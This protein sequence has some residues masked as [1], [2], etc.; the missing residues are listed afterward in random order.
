MQGVLPGA[1]LLRRRALHQPDRA[2]QL[3]QERVRLRHGRRHPRARLAP[4]LLK[5]LRRAKRA[6]RSVG[7]R[8]AEEVRMQ[9]SRFGG[10][11]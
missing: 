7:R 9:Q 5:L 2:Q 3:D 11:I 1:V 6:G 8:P 10:Q 4:R